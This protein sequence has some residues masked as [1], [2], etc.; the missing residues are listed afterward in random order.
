ME[1]ETVIDIH[2]KALDYLEEVKGID[3]EATD[4]HIAATSATILYLL[5]IDKEGD[6]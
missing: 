1:R 5:L 6:K 4:E 3:V 2:A